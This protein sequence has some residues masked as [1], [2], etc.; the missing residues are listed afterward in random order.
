MAT[1]KKT[2][3]KKRGPSRSPE[4]RIRELQEKIAD[5][6]RRKKTKELKKSPGAQQAITIIRALNKGLKVAEEE[7]DTSLKRSLA[8]AH[9]QVAAYLE[10]QGMKVPKARRPRGRKPKR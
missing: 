1:K 4:E 10:T 2:N 9:G 5:I 6:E 3:R 7:G 8:E